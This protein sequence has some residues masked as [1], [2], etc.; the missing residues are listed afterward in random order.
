[1]YVNGISIDD[2]IICK[3]K[4]K[5]SKFFIKRGNH[6]YYIREGRW[7]HVEATDEQLSTI[8]FYRYSSYSSKMFAPYKEM[9]FSFMLYNFTS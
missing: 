6:I 5:D 8:S 4:G 1:M 7:K 9:F 2:T 3:V